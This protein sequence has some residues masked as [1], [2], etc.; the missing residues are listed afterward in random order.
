M[1]SDLSSPSAWHCPL[2]DSGV[3]T[4]SGPDALAFLQG[5]TTCNFRSLPARHSTLG[6][7]CTAKGRVVALFRAFQH[8]EVIYVLMPC[9]LLETVKKRLS[10]YVLRAQVKIDH[11]AARYRAFGACGATI[12]ESLDL[13][14]LQ[15]NEFIPRGEGFALRIPAAAAPRWLLLAPAEQATAWAAR[16]DAAGSQSREEAAWRL[17]DIYAGL[18]CVMAATSEAFVPQMLN[19]DRL[20]GIALDKG[21]YTGQEIVARAHYLG[22]VKRRLYRFRSE[23][24]PEP[25]PG[26]AIMAGAEANAGEVV[27]A[28]PA[29][30]GGF[31]VLAVAQIALAETPGLAWSVSGTGQN[32]LPLTLHQ[33]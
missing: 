26:A 28:A 31:E 18:P 22:A 9:E 20:G 1:N 33:E 19:L 17:A 5:Q 30:G 11:A 8:E 2:A 10:L 15:E 32:T 14:T 29:P 6:A 13:P 21:C 16:L 27:C 25:A 23:Q 4:L 3:L 24:G 12:A 7:I